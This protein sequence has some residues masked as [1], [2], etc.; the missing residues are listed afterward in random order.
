MVPR[1]DRRSRARTGAGTSRRARGRPGEDRG[2]PARQTA[3][4]RAA[5]PP[6]SGAQPRDLPAPLPRRTRLGGTRRARAQGARPRRSEPGH[7]GLRQLADRARS[8]G[9]CR[10]GP[11]GPGRGRHP[12][13]GRGRRLAGARR[14][15]VQDRS[16][17]RP[18]SGRHRVGPCPA[19]RTARPAGPQGARLRGR[20]YRGPYTRHLRLRKRERRLE[21]SG[22]RRDAR[23]GRR[24]PRRTPARGPRP[25]AGRC[26]GRPG[27]SSA[28]RHRADPQHP[29]DLRPQGA[30]HAV[31]HGP[32]HPGPVGVR[33]HRGLRAEGGSVPGAVPV[34]RAERHRR[35]RG[36]AARAV[37]ARTGA[38]AAAHPGCRGEGLLRDQERTATFAPAPG[39]GRLRPGAR[40]KAPGLYLAGAWTATGWPA[41]M[42]SAVRSGV[43]A[44]AA[45]L[46][47][48]GRSRGLLPDFFEEA[49]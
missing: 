46:G 31:P 21:R 18:G 30:R 36:R 38:A 23:S 40:T 7:P 12:Q 19:G 33:P 35:A 44:A 32:R 9:A 45:A 16:A 41:T 14:D 4:R 15:G 25:A 8:V 29:R 34:D 5:R 11:V 26:A 24:R 17:V 43:G 3:A 22:S 48:L 1:P 13:R 39:V 27:K 37:P 28:D 42:E 47:A 6:A 2:Q 20:P 10:R 49:A